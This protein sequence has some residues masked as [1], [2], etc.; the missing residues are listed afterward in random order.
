LF[1]PS[2]DE[3]V[4]TVKNNPVVKVEWQDDS[5]LKISSTADPRN[6]LLA[7]TQWRTISVNNLEIKE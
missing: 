4:F 3:F 6:V 7:K 1:G 5:H 2:E